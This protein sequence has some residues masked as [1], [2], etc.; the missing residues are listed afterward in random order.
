MEEN[1]RHENGTD[2]SRTIEKRIRKQIRLGKM[3]K[4]DDRVLVK[5]EVSEHFLK[6]MHLKLARK[7]SYDKMVSVWTA[8]DEINSFFM[9]IIGKKEKTEK[10][11]AKIFTCVTDDELEEYCRLNKIRFKKNKKDKAAQEFLEGISAK[12]PDSKHKIIKSLL[13]LHDL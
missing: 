1:I 6:D 5:D 11:P 7:G 3:F 13:R 10:K 12:H 4:K 2:F 8:D 9:K